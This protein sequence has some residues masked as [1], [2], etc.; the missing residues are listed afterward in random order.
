M[1]YAIYLRKSGK[2]DD[3]GFADALSGHG[4]MPMGY[5]DRMGPA[6]HGRD[7]CREIVSGG[8]IEAGPQMQR[9]LKAVEMRT[10]TA[11]PCMESERLGRGDGA[12]RART[13]EAF[14][15]SDTKTVTPDK[16]CDLASDDGFDEGFFGFGL[17]MGRIIGHSV[18]TGGNDGG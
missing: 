8:G 9:L 12:D 5:A 1:T 18:P 6:V 11:V 3:A 7:I 10:Y 13:L 2:D 4:K 15:F 16:T 17:F 14:R